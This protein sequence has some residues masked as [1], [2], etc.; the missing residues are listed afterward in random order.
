MWAFHGRGLGRNTQ[1]CDSTG[2]IRCIP[3]ARMKQA[4]LSFVLIVGCSAQQD[5]ATIIQHS[6]EANAADW[7][8]YPRL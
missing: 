4:I 8:S 7:D 5:A 3:Q 2:A 1:A 6:V